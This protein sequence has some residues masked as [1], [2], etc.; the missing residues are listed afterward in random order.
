M[1]LFVKNEWLLFGIAFF[2]MITLVCI[3]QIMNQQYVFNDSKSYLFA[4]QQLYQEGIFNDHRPFL[5]NLINGFPLLFGGS[6]DAVFKWAVAVNLCCWF[7]TVLLVYRIAKMH[8]DEKNAFIAGLLFIFCISNL[9]FAFHLLSESIFVFLLIS[10]FYLVQQYFNTNRIGYLSC[11]IALLLLMV[12]VKPISSE[13]VILLLLYFIRKIKHLFWNRGAILMLCS[14]LLISIQ[15]FAMKKQYGSYAISYVNTFTYYNYLSTKADCLKNNIEFKEGKNERAVIFNELSHSAQKSAA[16]ADFGQQLK[17]NFI[18][19]IKA[20]C[21]NFYS[22]TTKGSVAVAVCENKNQANYYDFA[23]FFFK[24]LSKLQNIILTFTGILLSCYCLLRKKI[25]SSDK[26]LGAAVLYFIAM[27][28]ISCN[29]GDR[30]HIVIF[31][32]V[33]LLLVNQG[34]QLKKRTFFT[35]QM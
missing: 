16:A 33:I 3:M 32:F 28:A 21:V 15:L 26:L 5:I 17:H 4:A 8:S 19:L 10:A 14:V 6:A 18:N 29:Q 1:K 25:V 24:A 9:F 23:V 11:T 27:S 20:Y 34:I 12:L 7:S 2:W 30:F 22:N 13:L 31:P 35:R